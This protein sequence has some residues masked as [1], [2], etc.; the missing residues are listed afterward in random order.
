M[1]LIAIVLAATTVAACSNKAP[2]APPAEAAP[3][4][5][6]AGSYDVTQPDGTRMISVLNANGTYTDSVTGAVVEN[7]TWERKD[8]GSTCFTPA[9]GSAGKPACFTAG[10]A[11]ADG[12]FTA[13][14]D[15]GDPLKIKR[16]ELRAAAP[17]FFTSPPP[18]L[19]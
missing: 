18:A 2:E 8:N 14:P 15:S 6:S 17:R 1:K 3:V 9:E 16:I 7:G 12:S 13:T 11:A 10:A 4:E 19:R 5:I